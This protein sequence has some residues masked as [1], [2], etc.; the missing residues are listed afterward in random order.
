MTMDP[1]AIFSTVLPIIEDIPTVE[2]SVE[3]IFAAIKSMIGS[4][5][6]PLEILENAVQL[7]PEIASAIVINTPVAPPAPP[8]SQDQA[9]TAAS[10]AARN[11]A[12]QA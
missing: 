8:A 7:V 6:D 9:E 10:Q 3:A 12:A 4:G 2:K 11:V 1:F 5:G